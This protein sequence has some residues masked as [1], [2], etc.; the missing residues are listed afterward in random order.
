MEPCCNKPDERK[1]YVWFWPFKAKYCVNCKEVTCDTGYLLDLIW[2]YFVW[3][4]WKGQV[5]VFFKEGDKELMSLHE[6][7]TN[8]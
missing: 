1:A 2:Q 7:P 3:P 4:F 5:K 8:H 6:N